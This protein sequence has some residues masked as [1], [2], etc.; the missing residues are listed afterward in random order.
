M[1]TEFLTSWTAW[2]TR[3]PGLVLATL[4]FSTIAALYFAI[5]QFEMNS[6]TARLIRQDTQWRKNHDKFIDA[7]PQYELNTFVV[8][9]GPSPAIV[10][11]VVQ[12]LASN[13]RQY[14][15]LF[16]SVYAPTASEFADRHALLFMAAE[17]LNDTI[18]KLSDAQPFLSAIAEH[19]SM[20]G[21]L[22]LLSDALTSGQ[23]LPGGFIQ[24]TDAVAKAANQAS[25]G[26]D[27][28]IAWRD[29][30]FQLTGKDVHY[31][32]I[33]VQGN[34]DYQR[35]LPNALIL[36]RLDHTIS[37]FKHPYK[38]DVAIRL[39][40]IV[41]LDHGEIVSALDSAQLAGAIAM[42]LLIIVLVWGV[43]SARIIVA[44]YLS[45]LCGLIWTAAFAM[46]S[47]GQYNTISI[48]FLVMFIGLGVDFAV[49]LCLKFQEANSHTDKT[50]ALIRTGRDLGPAIVLCG[51]TSA[52]GF[53]AFVPTEYTGLAE[54]GIISGGG[55]IIAVVVSLT[56]IPAFF[57]VT[58]DP[59][60]AS[61]IPLANAMSYMVVGRQRKVCI[62][63]LVLALVSIGIGSQATFD[64]S[65]LSLKDPDSEAMTTLQELHDENVVTDY[66]LTYMA[67]D[68]AGAEA[69]KQPLSE[70]EIVGEVKTPIDYLPEN[71]SEKLY[72][73]E[74]AQF[75][76]GAI[77]HAEENSE[78]YQDSDH[79]QQ[80]TELVQ[81]IDIYLKSSAGR[82]QRND[83]IDESLRELKTSLKV[84]S[85]RDGS[86]R[87]AFTT[88]IIP[89]MKKEISWLQQAFSAQEVTMDSLP[90]EMRERLIGKD[91]QALVSI[92]PSE[93]VTP[94]GVMQ[95]FAEQ[96]SRVVPTATGRPVIELGIRDIVLSALF[97][98]IVLAV[99][100]IFVVLLLT[101]RSFVDSVL[102]FI[103]LA[104]TAMV[105][106]SFSVLADLPL[107]MANVVVIPLIFG[108]GVDNGIHIVKRFHQC[109]DVSELVRSSTP[110]AVLLSNLTTLGTF[111][112]LSC[113]SHQG[114]FSIGVLLSVALLSLMLLTLISLP[115]LLDTFSTSRSQTAGA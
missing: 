76:L 18:S 45:M 39:T 31:Q 27:K 112:A 29:E 3:R 44:T 67:D 38:E 85:E 42:A 54:M 113:S 96:V 20:R 78:H 80:L 14:D 41:A 55:M 16:S 71:Q 81:E 12:H 13:I 110:K 98:A 73:L 91:N 52:I 43:R 6:D 63:T 1:L 34:Q 72:L 111:G 109:R 35:D 90:S 68:L 114:I 19:N 61:E 46:V 5:S 101:L 86:S 37:S 24:I 107:N 58:K 26:S 88:L 7:F 17:Q 23:D 106:L 103:P 56:L 36:D 69:V 102:V 64:Y 8:V 40:G 47:V 93:D 74:D 28:P 87:D 97:T 15:D 33:F 9:S 99:S 50:T 22:T 32:V 4:F 100:T 2:V 60:P 95:R 104:M 84:L 21:V 66:T 89:P 83:T 115:A 108:L 105:T 62:L 25:A 53:L 92:T 77:F 65:T 30:L 51:V 82:P 10:R 57:A 59:K 49:H 48:I 11:E 79:Q 75:L 70:L 94:V